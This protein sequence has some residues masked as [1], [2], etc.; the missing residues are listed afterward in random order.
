MPQAG[1]SRT[2]S[3]SSR[4]SPQV[5]TSLASLDAYP[6]VFHLSGYH[7]KTPEE[8][9]SRIHEALTLSPEEDLAIHQRARTWAVQRF[10]E[11]EFE[12]AWEASEWWSKLLA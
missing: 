11:A 7:A 8:F 6:H 9:A 12:A 10:S 1:P 2:S 4:D 3:S 5:R